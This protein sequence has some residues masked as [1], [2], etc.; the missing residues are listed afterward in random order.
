MIKVYQTY[1]IKSYS[2]V[3]SFVLLSFFSL[4]IIL[5]IFEDY[6]QS[7]KTKKI[8]SVFLKMVSL[9]VVSISIFSVWHIYS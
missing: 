5:N 6:L 7:K 4:I 3:F 2:K 8:F 9:I 1:I